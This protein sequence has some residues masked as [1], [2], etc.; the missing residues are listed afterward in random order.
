MHQQHLEA[1]LVGIPSSRAT[2]TS[3]HTQATLSLTVF[4]ASTSRLYK[5]INV[6]SEPFSWQV[7]GGVEPG[8]LPLSLP[9]ASEGARKGPKSLMCLWLV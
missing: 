9:L 3:L 4:M 5:S 2:A 8:A 1:S 7:R 6:S